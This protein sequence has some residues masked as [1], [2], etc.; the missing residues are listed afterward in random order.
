MVVVPGLYPEIMPV[1]SPMPATD[2]A[3]LTHVPPP[4]SDSV[5]DVPEHTVPG[6][7]IA[8]GKGFTV[9]KVVLKQP[10]PVV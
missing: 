5:A 4:G 1:V 6:P 9:K 8:A 3:E 7:E 10:G 2:G